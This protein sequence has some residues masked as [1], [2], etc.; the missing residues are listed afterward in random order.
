MR[1]KMHSSFLLLL[2]NV[3]KLIKIFNENNKRYLD[4]TNKNILI[5]SKYID[6]Y[7]EKIQCVNSVK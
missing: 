5:K 6:Q 3:P 1:A 2:G 7:D 4:I